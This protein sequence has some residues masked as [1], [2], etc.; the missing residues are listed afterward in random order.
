MKLKFLLVCLLATTLFN[1]CK[2]DEEEPTTTPTTST[3]KTLLIDKNWKLTAYT[4]NPAYHQVN[5]GERNQAGLSSVFHINYMQD[6]T[7]FSLCLD[8]KMPIQVFDM[9]KEGNLKKAVQGKPIGTLIDANGD[10]EFYE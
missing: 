1:G 2:K 3:N 7:A 5:M 9:G 8:N 6:S 4:V 10:S